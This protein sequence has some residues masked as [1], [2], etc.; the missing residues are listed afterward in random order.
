ML[1]CFF[2]TLYA[3]NKMLVN[4][5]IGYCRYTQISYFD[6]FAEIIMYEYYDQENTSE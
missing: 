6:L 4:Q 1:T 2:A 3:V 5:V